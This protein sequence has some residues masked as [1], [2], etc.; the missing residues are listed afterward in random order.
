M[1]GA[2]LVALTADGHAVLTL[3]P[4]TLTER[5]RLVLPGPCDRLARL[6]PRGLLAGTDDGR[7]LLLAPDTMAGAWQVAAQRR[8]GTG[9]LHPAGSRDGRWVMVATAG[10]PAGAPAAAAAGLVGPGAPAPQLHLLGAG[11]QPVRTWPLPG[12]VAWLAD[13]AHRQ[14]FVLALAT[15]PAL[16]TLSYDE[17]AEDFYEGLVHD[18][19]MGE[20]V[21]QRGYLNVRRMPLPQPLLAG[22]LDAEDTEIAGRGWVFNLDARRPVARVPA[23]QPPQA[24]GAALLPAPPPASAPG[25]AALMSALM[26]VP[27]PGQPVLALWHTGRWQPAGQAALPAPAVQ[28]L[29]LPAA[30]LSLTPSAS[31]VLLALGQ[32]G[33]LMALSL[34]GLQLLPARPALPPLRQ[35]LQV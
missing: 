27:V 34:P 25:A 35:L 33:R 24:A 30:G 8:L 31:G 22:C 12:P 10:A 2:R 9:P 19:R 11:L 6:G 4:V 28:V 16:W 26:A 3:D 14:A 7:V 15:Q 5:A 17:H 32:D 23:L 1:A 13:A 29:A 18:Y 20:G 21:P